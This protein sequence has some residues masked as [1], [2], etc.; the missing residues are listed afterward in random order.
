MQVGWIFTICPIGGPQRPRRGQCGLSA[1][2]CPQGDGL[3]ALGP[4]PAALGVFLV[5]EADSRGRC[6]GHT[7][8]VCETRVG[9]G[10]ATQ[11][12]WGR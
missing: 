5:N 12:E 11:A 3:G 6:S 2:R 4:S 9:G 1:A 10:A 7:S 8:R